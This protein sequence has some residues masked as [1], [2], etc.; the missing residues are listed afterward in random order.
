MSIGSG[1]RSDFQRD[2]MEK[3]VFP[4]NLPP[5]FRV[6]NFHDVVVE[7]NLFD[8][9]QIERNRPLSL[10]RYNETKRGGQRRIFSTPNP[11]F[12]IDVAS[13]LGQHRRRF[14]RSLRRSPI[15]Y[16][17]PQYDH[18][19]SR[20]IK[21]SSFSEFTAERRRLLSTSRY[22]VKT[23]IS[24]FFPSIYTH[25]I[26]WAVHGKTESKLDRRRN[27]TTVFANKLDYLV[28]QAQDQQTIGIPVGPDTSRIISELVASAIDEEFRDQ[29]GDEVIGARLVDDIFLGADTI[30][31]ADRYLS[32]YRDAI[33][34]YELDI[35]ENKTRIFEARND[36][37]AYWPVSIRRKL[38]EFSRHPATR[39]ARAD[40][41]AYLD[42]IIRIANVEK[43]DG[44]IKYSIR[45]MDDCHL[46][47]DYWLVVEP[48]LMRVAVNFPHCL[49]YV[50]RVVV[51]RNRRFEVDVE[52]W[53]R[54][55]ET[56]I[57]YHAERGN[58]SEVVWGCWLLK[59]LERNLHSDICE[60]AINRCG[61]FSVLMLIDL[62][63]EGL[64]SGRFP[65]SNL[66]DRLGNNPMIGNDWLVSYE[67]E[68]TFGFRLR[69]K[70]R[71]DYSVFGDLID[72]GAAFYDSDAQPAVFQGIE[73]D[74]EVESALEDESGFYDDDEDDDIDIDFDLEGFLE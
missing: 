22:I 74:D 29:V 34:K 65:R 40:L 9:D 3:G 66:L 47:Q 13:Y 20:C 14:A 56:T 26:P 49:D 53:A 62:Y 50:A 15:S 48:F 23:D 11:L 1:R 60:V 30:E 27:S 69:T 64:I 36:L 38:D 68:R 2:I 41:T 67:A 31:E 72:E 5:V 12:F 46:W 16:S 58:D 45:K 59:E 21:I 57:S 70:N 25:S 28:R 19:A 18:L 73:N 6:S 32:A 42:E 71:N 7:Q 63:A 33:R 44:I 61:A 8:A 4:E 24:R 51:W 17:I 55:C 52:R 43:D 37:E 35:N 10:A 39:N 54:V